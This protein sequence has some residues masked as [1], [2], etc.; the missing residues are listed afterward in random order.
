MYSLNQQ[1]CGILSAATHDP[2]D[3]RRSYRAR[4]PNIQGSDTK[5]AATQSGQN[6]N[7]S[8]RLAAADAFRTAKLFRESRILGIIPAVFAQK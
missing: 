3:L 8:A 7:Q 5:T 6:G 4:K 2:K 1:K